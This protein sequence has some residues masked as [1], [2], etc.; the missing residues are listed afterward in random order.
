MG[1]LYT[2]EEER[3]AQSGLLGIWK[4]SILVDVRKNNSCDVVLPVS[5]KDAG[6]FLPRAQQ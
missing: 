4:D 2:F 1:E 3:P 6:I 5:V